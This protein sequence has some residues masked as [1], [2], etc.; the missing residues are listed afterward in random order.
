[1][2]QADMAKFKKILIEKRKSVQ[3]HVNDLEEQAL[4]RTRQDAAGDLSSLPDHMADLGTDNYEQEFNL[5]LLEGS[6]I[7]LKDVDDALAKTEDGTFGACEYCSEE[8]PRGRLEM[9]PH[10]RYCLKCQTLKEKGML[11]EEEPETDEK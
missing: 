5:G 11:D 1:M 4:K 2:K 6:A 9:V 7:N 8:I 3:G 10:A